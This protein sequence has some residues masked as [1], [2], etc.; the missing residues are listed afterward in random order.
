MVGKKLGVATPV[1]DH[2]TKMVKEIEAGEREITPENIKELEDMGL[3]KFHKEFYEGVMDEY[4]D[5]TQCIIWPKPSMGFMLS[6]R[7]AQP[8]FEPNAPKW[9]IPEPFVLKIAACGAYIMPTVNPNQPLTQ[10]KINEQVEKSID[11]GACAC[12]I[13]VRDDDGMHTL[14]LKRFHDVIDNLREKYGKENLLIDGC[15]EGGKD[16][17]DTCGPLIEFKDDWETCPLTCTSVWLGNLLF[18]PSTAKATKGMAKIME[19]IGIKPEM[20]CHDLGDIDN[21]RR[22][23]IDTGIVKKP[24]YFR[25]CMGQPGWGTVTNPRALMDTYRQACD[26]ILE[27]D[28]DSRVMVS[29]SGRAGIWGVMLAAMYGPPIIGARVGMEDSIWMRPTDDDVIK[30]NPSVIANLVK[31]LEYLGRRP[32]TANEYREMLDLPKIFDEK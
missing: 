8:F 31:G 15:P 11:L 16:F 24:Y 25:I 10:A 23:L 32:A 6:D 2:I 1:N 4:K 20:V 3:T 19:D 30:D 28:P 27:I 13:H 17:L 21:A 22:W 26:R 29:M 5:V 18:V 7:Y 14:E 12:H 9:N